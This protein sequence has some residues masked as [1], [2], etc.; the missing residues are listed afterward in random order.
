V[1][2][3]GLST[4]EVQLLQNLSLSQA[5]RF[6]GFIFLLSNNHIHL[7]QLTSSQYLIVWASQLRYFAL[8]QPWT[9][10]NNFIFATSFHNSLWSSRH[11][12]SLSLW[13]TYSSS[14]QRSPNPKLCVYFQ[15]S[16]CNFGAQCKFS[17][18]TPSS[19]AVQSPE[20]TWRQEERDP[21]EDRLRE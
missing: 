14:Y 19:R 16:R 5:F 12:L 10:E 11:F 1:Y 3:F 2:C 8:L 9:G 4:Y 21:A 18:E 6:L 15:R 7:I 13:L 20:S 17:H